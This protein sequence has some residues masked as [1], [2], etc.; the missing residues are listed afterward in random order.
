MSHPCRAELFVACD[1]H[2][3]HLVFSATRDISKM[4]KSAP[5][6][7]GIIPLSSATYLLILSSQLMCKL[8][9]LQ[10]APRRH[11]ASTPRHYDRGAMTRWTGTGWGRV[12][13][14]RR[15]GQP[16][17]PRPRK[18]KPGAESLAMKDSLGRE[19]RW[20][21]D[22]GRARKARLNTHCVCRCFASDI[23]LFP[24]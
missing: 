11:W 3:N 22:S 12:T 20:N 10:P 16:W 6:L 17:P 23:F 4:M 1:S 24:S 7:K 5:S 2:C 18:Q 21:A 15:T 9:D 13:P 19:P 8:A 14:A